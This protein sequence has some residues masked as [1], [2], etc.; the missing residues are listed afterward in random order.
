MA[1]FSIDTQLMSTFCPFFFT[2]LY[3]FSIGF[4]SGE[5]LGQSLRYCNSHQTARFITSS[6]KWGCLACKK[7]LSICQSTLP[8]YNT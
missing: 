5:L 1:A 4:R 3:K 2:I 8:D 6:M 7:L